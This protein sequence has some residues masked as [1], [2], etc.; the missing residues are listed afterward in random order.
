MADFLTGQV[1]YL[2][3]A[4]GL[5][6]VLLAAVSITMSREGPL[7]VPWW[8]LAAFAVTL[9]AAHW[10]RMAAPLLSA[11]G[12][13]VAVRVALTATAFVFLLEFDR[14]CQRAI[15]GTGPGPWVHG[16]LLAL[17]AALS[18]E[19]GG[20]SALASVRLALGLPAAVW[21]GALFLS[22]AR[23]EPDRG[24]ARAPRRA[25]AAAGAGFVA[26]AISI[27]PGL[28]DDPIPILVRE[29]L[30]G[31]ISLAIWAYAVSLDPKGRLLRKRWVSFWLS[32][33]TLLLVLAG[34]W[35]LTERLG[36]IHVRDAERD[37]EAVAGQVE[38]HFL[39]EV[40]VASEQAMALARLASGLELVGD[41]ASD[42]ARL[43]VVVDVLAAEAPG[44]VVYVL[45]ASGVAIAA[46][47]RDVPGSFLGRDYSH[48]PY[49]LEAIAGRSGR[50]LGMGVTTGLPGAFAGEPVRDARG[51]IVAVAAAK[52]TLTPDAFGPIRSANALLVDPAG[53]VVIPERPDPFPAQALAPGPSV[54]W[55]QV[56]GI[57][58][59]LV[60][61]PLRDTGWS[62]VVHRAVASPERNRLLG[63]VITL[64]LCVVVVGAFVA[65]QHQYGDESRQV[66]KRRRAELRALEL[67]RRADTDALTGLLN[68]TGFDAVMSRELARARRHGQPLS[69]VIVDLDHFKCVNDEHGHSEGDRVL[70]DVARLLEANVRESDYVARWGGEEFAVV[71]P[72]TSAPGA[73]R[74]AE[75]I[76]AL[77]E[78]SGIGPRNP[79]TGSFGVSQ[80]AHGEDLASLVRRADEALYVAKSSGRN[81]VV[82][83]EAGG[84]IEEPRACEP[85]AGPHST[86]AATGFA[87]I[88]EDHRALSAGLDHL[89]R[90][91]AREDGMGGLAALEALVAEVES[92][93][94][95]E[96]RYM[97][98]LGYPLERRHR[99]AHALFLEEARQLVAEVRRAGVTPEVRQR[100]AGPLREWFRYHI[101]AHDAGLGH[102]LRRAASESMPDW[103][104]ET[105]ADAATS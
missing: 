51:A 26:F 16:A 57:P 83:A 102:F 3:F 66:R 89:A 69:L 54:A 1:D 105:G 81:R 15:V 70:V 68:R 60:R 47:N 91:M 2:L 31:W 103:T 18:L 65:Q 12:S 64:L 38:D 28:G 99:E 4:Y 72:M 9:G 85:D 100:V 42:R 52:R 10:L 61:R 41:D 76:R 94:G 104:L 25:L 84:A 86:Y 13:V 34:G 90:V 49:F 74:L 82:C 40:D 43:D 77:L 11:G 8:L 92:H 71:V 6:L 78:T 98:E 14:R 27:L 62:L 58:Q 22:A 79:V 97:S 20:R 55:S 96:E 17:A 87:P 101:L 37:A 88:D 19:S 48:R 59:L 45:D 75:K 44:L 39:M 36:G 29:L 50:Y 32:A 73:V 95:H 21:A 63:I 7:P 46:S 56:E 67:A 93:F 24:E 33:G 23:R 5:V 80:L 30:F 53:H 35:M